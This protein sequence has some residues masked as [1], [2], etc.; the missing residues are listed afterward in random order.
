M[1][2]ELS[3]EGGCGGVGR[4]RSHRLPCGAVDDIDR[5]QYLAWSRTWEAL[6]RS[7]RLGP[8]RIESR[9]VRCF[10]RLCRRIDPTVVLEI[11]AHEASFSRWAAEALPDAE[12]R[13]FEANPHVHQKY[14]AELADTRVDYRNLA[15]GP[16]NGEVRLNVPTDVWGRKRELSN[17][18]AS[19][20]VNTDAEDTVSVTVQ[21][22]RLEDHLTLAGDDRVVAWIDVEGA[23]EIVLTGS[24]DAL[25]RT[26]AVFVEVESEPIWEGQWLDSDVATYLRDHGLVPVA[27]DVFKPQRHQY[28]VIFAR[29]DEALDPETVG[30]AAAVVMPGRRAG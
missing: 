11:G 28:N 12:V 6:A 10:R 13:A 18:M 23:N 25:D 4:G 21:S 9:L 15:V 8:R 19:L 7:S 5:S 17:R 14:A 29:P 27:R 2:A 24:G 30:Q 22:V 16:V 26:R 20:G 1:L 3:G